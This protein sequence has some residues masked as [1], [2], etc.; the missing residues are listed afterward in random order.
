[1]LGGGMREPGVVSATLPPNCHRRSTCPKASS[2][3]SMASHTACYSFTSMRLQSTRSG[4]P[5]CH[6]GTLGAPQPGYRRVHRGG[7]VDGAGQHMAAKSVPC[8]CAAIGTCGGGSG[9]PIVCPH[10]VALLAAAATRQRW[11][12]ALRFLWVGSCGLPIVG[13]GVCEFPMT[14]QTSLIRLEQCVAAAR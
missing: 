5:R 2:T 3:I 11:T 12:T 1:M 7:S 4:G 14:F 6:G 9:C 13:M 8:H 10:L